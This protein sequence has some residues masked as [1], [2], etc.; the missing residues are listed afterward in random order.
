MLWGHNQESHF[1]SVVKSGYC[2]TVLGMNEPNEKGQSNMSPQDGV[3]LWNRSIR[4]LKKKYG[5]RLVSPATT[6]GP[7][8]LKWQQEF[9]KACGG[10]CDVD[11]IA[12]H[13]YNNNLNDFKAR[14]N[15]YHQAFPKFPIWVTE[16]A[17]HSFNG[18]RQLSASEVREFMREAIAWMETQTWIER[19]F[20]F[21]AMPDIPDG[22]GTQNQLMAHDGKPNDLGAQFLHS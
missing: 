12:L 4:P 22:V 15:A 13:W 20:W 11:V 3:T 19:F 8:G 14:L 2:K 9:F 18:G 16:F 10:D 6:C 17:A 21:G 1:N 5:M 7:D